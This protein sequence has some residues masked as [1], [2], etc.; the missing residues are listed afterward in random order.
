MWKQR[1]EEY[2]Y[3]NKFQPVRE[4]W[5]FFIPSGILLYWYVSHDC[6]SAFHVW[7]VGDLLKYSQLRISASKSQ[8]GE[9]HCENLSLA[10]CFLWWWC[11]W[12]GVCDPG[13][14]PPSF[15]FPASCMNHSPPR[16]GRSHE[17]G[18]CYWRGNPNLA[19]MHRLKYLSCSRQLIWWRHKGKR[20][21]NKPSQWKCW[22]L[23]RQMKA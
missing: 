23:G 17:S 8:Y 12:M 1:K 10:S 22:A 3:L 19:S 5:F 7:A 11:V 15:I 14:R 13:E 18:L 21:E 9:Q 6:V 4:V 20:R 2:K 16:N